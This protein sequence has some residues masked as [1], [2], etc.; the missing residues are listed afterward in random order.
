MQSRGGA[1]MPDEAPET[2]E[3]YAVVTYRYLRLAIVV[4]TSSLLI[5]IAFEAFGEEC[6]VG[7]I[8]GYYYTPVRAVFVGGL[9]AIGVCLIAIKEDTP[10]KDS[11]LNLS[12][13]LAPIVAFVPTT[14]PGCGCTSTRAGR[15]D[16]GPGIVNNIAA[17]AIAGAIAIVIGAVVAWKHHEKFGSFDT[18]AL[19]VLALAGAMLGAGLAW[20]FRWNRNFLDHA[21]FTSAIGLF[22]VVGVVM[23]LN[24]LDEEKR[25]GLRRIYFGTAGFMVVGAVATVIVDRVILDNWQHQ[26]LTLELV[27]M[28]AFLAYWAVQTIQHWDAGIKGAA[29]ASPL[30]PAAA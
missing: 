15:F 9:I 24:A 6:A 23:V 3:S 19:T 22:A 25:S 17:Y 27:A 20:Y 18:A 16:T 2:L 28:A 26:V 4:V 8:S 30:P 13:A 11:L 1:K 12:G 10:L 14:F 29:P 7:S 21:H 5:S